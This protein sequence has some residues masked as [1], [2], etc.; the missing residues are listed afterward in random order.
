[1]RVP[2]QFEAI[3]FVTASAQGRVG[4]VTRRF[5]RDA[6]TIMI[7]NRAE[8]VLARDTVKP[9]LFEGGLA[10]ADKR[11]LGGIRVFSSES[12]PGVRGAKRAARTA[13]SPGR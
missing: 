13:R 11:Q 10:S 4:G 12:G 7:N 3:V 9:T 1:M 6:F 5:C 8:P 2:R